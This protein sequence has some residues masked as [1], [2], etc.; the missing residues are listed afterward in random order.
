MR[1]SKRNQELKRGKVAEGV[2]QDEEERE[3]KGVMLEEEKG[4]GRKEDGMKKM[5]TRA[6]SFFRI[7]IPHARTL[8][9]VGL[10]SS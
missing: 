3:E 5:P 8:V 4:K 1:R 9:L 7:S 10:L 6:F 2:I